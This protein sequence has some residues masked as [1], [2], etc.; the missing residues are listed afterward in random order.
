MSESHVATRGQIAVPVTVLGGRPMRIPTAGKIHAGIQVLTAAAAS[1][2]EIAA[3]YQQGVRDNISFQKITHLIL[4]QF[5]QVKRPLVPKNVPWFTVRP[6]DFP[7][8]EIAGQIMALYGEDRGDGLHLYRFPVIFPSDTWQMIMPHELV[9]WSANDKRY[10]SEYAADGRTRH[11]M[12]FAPAKVHAGSQRVVRTFGGRVKQLR[13]DNGGVCDPECCPQFQLRK[14]NLSGRFV[15]YLPG[16]PSLDAFELSTNSFY[17]M[18]RAIER[19]QAISFM[20]GGKIAGYLDA[21]RSTFFITKMLRDVSRIDN[22]GRPVKSANW[23]IELEAPVDVAALLADQHDEQILRQAD[24]SMRVLGVQPRVAAGAHAG[25]D[26]TQLDAPV[27][28]RPDSE[29]RWLDGSNPGADQANNR[30]ASDPTLVLPEA[31]DDAGSAGVAKPV[32]P[33]TDTSPPD[34]LAIWLRVQECGIV[35]A[36]FERFATKTW[37]SGWHLNP[38][39]RQRVAAELVR[40]ANHPEGLQD[41]ITAVLQHG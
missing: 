24:Q 19:F 34:L 12:T 15:F 37:G 17:A 8:R 20:R 29:E 4:E 23:I 3:I 13:E 25:D 6:E 26:F 10:W 7:N 38:H 36:D 5:P 28:M 9:S 41:K 2:P 22:D 32:G 35:R 30:H 27:G 31:Q 1:N 18:S 14:C 11:C 39:G 40:F 21:K 16:I 33:Q